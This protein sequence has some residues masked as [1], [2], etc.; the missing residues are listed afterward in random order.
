MSA[1]AARLFSGNDTPAPADVGLPPVV[2]AHGD[3]DLGAFAEERRSGTEI[4]DLGLD[5]P[6]GPSV[7]TTAA[8]ASRDADVPGGV[9][10]DAQAIL[11]GERDAATLIARAV[12]TA[13]QRN[14]PRVTANMA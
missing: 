6:V 9:D 3:I 11:P 2:D 1:M 12:A 7:G 8:R 10:G 13:S 14:A 5:E 4:D